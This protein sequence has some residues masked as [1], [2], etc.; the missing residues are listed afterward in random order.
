MPNVSLISN[1]QVY[2]PADD[3]NISSFTTADTVTINDD[4]G[5]GHPLVRRLTYQVVFANYTSV[6]VKAQGTVDDVTWADISGTVI[7]GITT[8]DTFSFSTLDN[9]GPFLKV[10]FQVQGTLSGSTD[11]IDVYK[12]TELYS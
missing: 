8:G 2:N 1:V 4:A 7:S 11:T 3:T 10:R 6:N 5:F 9:G 12:S